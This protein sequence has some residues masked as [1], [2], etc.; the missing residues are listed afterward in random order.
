LALLR[1]TLLVNASPTLLEKFAVPQTPC[2]GGFLAVFRATCNYFGLPLNE[3]PVG[4]GYY[5]SI[6]LLELDVSGFDEMT[7]VH[8]AAIGNGLTRTQALR[9]FIFN[10][11][12]KE[13]KQEAWKLLLPTF[14]QGTIWKMH[15]TNVNLSSSM[16]KD[17]AQ[18]MIKR[19]V[20]VVVDLNL[21]GAKL[22]AAAVDSLCTSLGTTK[23]T[24]RRMTFSNCGLTGDAAQK[25]MTL[26]GKKSQK[27]EYLD[28]SKNALGGLGAPNPLNPIW[29]SPKLEAVIVGKTNIN[30][31]SLTDGLADGQLGSLKFLDISELKLPPPAKAKKL[32]AAIGPNIESI[33][34]AGVFKTAEDLAVYLGQFNL[35]QKAPKLAMDLSGDRNGLRGVVLATTQG[36]LPPG[37]VV[38]T[39]PHDI[40]AAAA[41]F[42]QME[43]A[44][45]K[46]YH[47]NIQAG[48]TGAPLR[49]A[50]LKLTLETA[51][52]TIRNAAEWQS[53]VEPVESMVTKKFVMRGLA[54]NQSTINITL[55]AGTEA[56]H[57]LG[58]KLER[59]GTGPGM[60]L[61]LQGLAKNKGIKELDISDCTGG[62]TVAQVLGTNVL[63]VN[64]TLRS[65]KIGGNYFSHYGLG[66]IRGALYGNKK[67]VEFPFPE[68]DSQAI[69]T[70]YNATISQLEQSVLGYKAQIKRA[71]KSTKGARTPY[72][73]QTLN[74]NVGY[75]KDAKT[76]AARARGVV[77]KFAKVQNEIQ[78]AIRANQAD[79]KNQEAFAKESQK[80]TKAQW[81][82]AG[83]AL[84]KINT[85]KQKQVEMTNSQDAALWPKRAEMAKMWNA[86]NEELKKSKKEAKWLDGWIKS[87][88]KP[89]TGLIV[90]GPAAE[91]LL[92]MIPAETKWQFK[93]ETP[94]T[95]EFI[96]IEQEAKA[97]A[98]LMNCQIQ[99]QNLVI[100]EC[101]NNPNWRPPPA[102]EI[103]AGLDPK[104]TAEVTKPPA[105]GKVSVVNPPSDVI[106]GKIVSVQPPPG[107]QIVT[108]TV[109]GQ[110]VQA[111]TT[112]VQPSPYV[113]QSE[114]EQWRIYQQQQQLQAQ[115]YGAYGGGA[116]GRPQQQ[117]STGTYVAG[118]AAVGLGIGFLAAYQYNHYYSYGWYD[119]PYYCG[120]GPRPYGYYGGYYGDYYGY[121]YGGYYGH[122]HGYGGYDQGDHMVDEHQDTAIAASQ[123]EFS[124][125]EETVA[126][127]YLPGE[128]GAGLSDEIGEPPADFAEMGGFM[129]GDGGAGEEAAAEDVG[130]AAEAVEMYAGG[131]DD[132][133]GRGPRPGSGSSAVRAGPMEVWRPMPARL[134]VK[135]WFEERILKAEHSAREGV[136]GRVGPL[137]CEREIILQSE[138]KEKAAI[139]LVTQCSL[140]RLG[141]LEEQLVLWDGEVSVA[142][143]ADAPAVGLDAALARQAVLETCARAAAR[144]ARQRGSKSDLP[145]SWTVTLV[146][147]L[148]STDVKCQA[149][150]LLYPINT[151]RNAA[152]ASARAELLFLLDVD[153]V[154]SKDL[155][156]MLTGQDGGAQLLDALRSKQPQAGLQSG[157]GIS[158]PASALVIPAFES[159]LSK[160]HLPRSGFILKEA[161][162]AGEVEGF[163]VSHFPRGHRA[164]NFHRW[165][166]GLDAGSGPEYGRFVQAS[167]GVNAYPVQYEEHFEP[168]VV[169]ARADVPAYDERFRGYGLNKISHLYEMS[170]RGFSF[171]T[172]D[173]TD[174]FVIAGKHPKSQSWQSCVGPDAEAEQRARLATHYETF[175]LEL[176]GRSAP[177]AQ[178][179]ASDLVVTGRASVKIP[180]EMPLAGFAHF[181]AGACGVADMGGSSHVTSE[182]TPLLAAQA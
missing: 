121:G 68:V 11:K 167:H 126:A 162:E 31:E 4:Q 76:K 77:Q 106:C 45:I 18:A 116:Y 140:D 12:G 123:Y 27:L 179:A 128:E 129:E 173:S 14:G 149:Y 105:K 150:D 144:R 98:Q 175:K 1:A 86:K 57:S 160:K 132:R 60:G 61:M 112:V 97:K 25:L 21:S 70:C 118:G 71:F 8:A 156:S 67:L 154:P 34:T 6:P 139:C 169:V 95:I 107:E 125:V 178:P 52:K 37:G 83:K 90:T 20:N 148:R 3:V 161:Y 115:Q 104:T 19:K 28:V 182:R 136:L 72:V 172:I 152:L 108:G 53:M 177:R 41:V 100:T 89:G 9:G 10:G 146:Y 17:L 74:T 143:F 93:A 42:N 158:A 80:V 78:Q 176:R 22:D 166:A 102:A 142:V 48:L 133:P 79:R 64:R 39:P 75:I 38:M 110:Q 54:N 155:Y 7:P 141:R 55:E 73:V 130:D 59:T 63:K 23:G 164:T 151:L 35:P 147:Q 157:S 51:K 26:I 181:L 56:I 32:W 91:A 168:Y 24:L 40:K 62:D 153:F 135:E 65:L 47:T 92:K 16:V 49:E 120:W 50:V 122:H 29:K 84:A 44:I 145:L 159:V 94:K 66:A 138:S 43:P 111:P 113:Q 13:I 174:A 119:D 36:G 85:L 163:H 101:K 170:V 33:G 81:K 171:L 5:S 58:L 69:I 180:A 114:Y 2:D 131:E 30:L 165:F 134:D 87:N 96:K 103:P 137:P 46:H 124:P 15:I 82:K 88:T 117:Y 127:D 109:V 99:E